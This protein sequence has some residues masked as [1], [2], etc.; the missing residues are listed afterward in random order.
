MKQN[1]VRKKRKQLKV[2]ERKTQGPEVRHQG[3]SARTWQ[4]RGHQQHCKGKRESSRRKK[5][6]GQPEAPLLR[7]FRDGGWR[8]QWRGSWRDHC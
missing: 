8:D 7:S 1:S 6:E 2:I 3:D 4:W 5:Q